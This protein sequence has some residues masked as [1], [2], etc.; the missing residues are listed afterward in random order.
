[1]C[2]QSIVKS[3]IVLLVRLLIGEK[4]ESMQYFGRAQNCGHLFSCLM[5]FCANRTK[6]TPFPTMS[7][8]S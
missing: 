8:E 7:R 2:I 3:R 6:Q 1:M 4:F 5:H